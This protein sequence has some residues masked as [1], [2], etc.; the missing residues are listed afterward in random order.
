M[1]ANPIP[2][3]PP[4][5]GT[6][7]PCSPWKPCKCHWAQTPPSPEF[8][9]YK[10]KSPPWTIWWFRILGIISVENIDR[11]GAMM[12]QTSN[13]SQLCIDSQYSSQKL[14]I[15]WCL[16]HQSTQPIFYRVRVLH[17][18][19]LKEGTLSHS[20]AWIWNLWSWFLVMKIH[21]LS[22]FLQSFYGKFLGSHKSIPICTGKSL[23]EALILAST[24]PKYDR[25]LFIESRVQYMKTTNS[26]NKLF[27]FCIDNSK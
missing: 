24:N 26:E 10:I 17:L 15:V 19:R 6:F 14:T 23:S 18:D 16:T 9:S 1:D 4:G 3:D 27:C 5:F 2:V 13:N 8:K 12:F 11:L 22:C 21:P 7:N 20:F 25:K